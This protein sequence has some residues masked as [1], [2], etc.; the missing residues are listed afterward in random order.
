MDY[1]SNPKATHDYEILETMEAGLV[2][3]GSEV[4]SIKTGKASIKGAYVKILRGAPYLVGAVIAP[5]QPGNMPEDYKDQADHKLLIKHSQLTSLIGLSKERGAALVP[6]KLYETRGLIKLQV[7]IARGKKS[8][9]KRAT[10]AKK[11]VAR[12]KQRGTYE[13]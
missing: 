12:S 1:A 3:S 7:G 9:D 10:I 2:L 13:E 11:D 5:Y 8:H 4:K 6:L